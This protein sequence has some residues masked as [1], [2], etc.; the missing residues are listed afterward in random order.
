MGA[1]TVWYVSRSLS[2]VSRMF[3]R[4]MN[5][6]LGYVHFWLTLIAVYGVF[7]QCTLLVC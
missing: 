7:F 5:K 4:M 3:G 1:S 2:L 6:T